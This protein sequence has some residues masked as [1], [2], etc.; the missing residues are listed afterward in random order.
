AYDWYWD[1]G[2]R[3]LEHAI[4]NGYL[5]ARNRKFVKFCLLWANHNPAHSSSATDLEAVTNYWL[6]HYFHLPEYYTIDGRPVVIIFSPGRFTEDMGAPAVKEA[7]ARIR[8]QC[9]AAG[10]PGI[11][12]V[13]CVNGSP[14]EMQEAADEGYDAASGYNYPGVNVS[15]GS[16]SAPYATMVPG[17]QDVWNRALGTPALPYIAPTAPGWDNR[18][19]AGDRAL[20]RT[21]STPALFAE[22]LRN[23]RHFADAHPLTTKE[24]PRK[25]V[26]VEAWNEFGEGDYVEPCRG[27]GFG[28]LDAIRDVFGAGGQ[29]V[30]H[31]D[32]VPAD[33]GMGPYELLPVPPATHWSFT[34]VEDALG[35]SPQNMRDFHAAADGL[36]ATAAT[37]DPAFIGPAMNARAAAYSHVEITLS[38]DAGTD[39]QLFWATPGN[40]FSEGQSIH[41]TTIPDGKPHTYTILVNKNPTWT[42]HI[43]QLRVDPSSVAGSGAVL[44]GVGLMAK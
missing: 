27:F 36:H 40:P 42:G 44:G 41:F 34:K 12:F 7:F 30:A 26:L 29:A 6:A 2:S 33:L 16:L 37:D 5:K 9:R 20:V 10:L 17:Y 14:G 13:A 39:G 31:T 18:P 22:M 3:S 4:D 24:G 8:E 1:R 19:W 32:L 11:Y 25:V 43:T 28:M 38:V 15:P 35:W 23:A 21:G